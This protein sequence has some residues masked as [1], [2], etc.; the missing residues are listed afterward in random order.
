MGTF[1]K[2]VQQSDIMQMWIVFQYHNCV[3]NFL[4]TLPIKL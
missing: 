1:E 3:S 2:N 4:F